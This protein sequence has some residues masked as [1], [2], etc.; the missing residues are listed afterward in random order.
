MI[1]RVHDPPNTSSRLSRPRKS[2]KYRDS[3][4]STSSASD[5]ESAEDLK[6]DPARVSCRRRRHE[7]LQA[8]LS[9]VDS[10]EDPFEEIVIRAETYFPN[11]TNIVRD[12]ASSYIV[13]Q[14]PYDTQPPTGPSLPPSIPRPYIQPRRPLLRSASASRANPFNTSTIAEAKRRAEEELDRRIMMYSRSH[15]NSFSFYSQPNYPGGGG[16]PYQQSGPSCGG[17]YCSQPQ[18]SQS[19]CNNFQSQLQQNQP[20]QQL[21]DMDER[22]TYDYRD[23]Q[24]ARQIFEQ[25]STMGQQQAA[26]PPMPRNHLHRIDLRQQNSVAS[27]NESLGGCSSGGCGPGAICPLSNAPQPAP[28][29]Q[30]MFNSQPT[31]MEPQNQESVN[32]GAIMKRE[33]RNPFAGG[34]GC[35]PGA[36]CGA[37]PDTPIHRG[38]G[39]PREGIKKFLVSEEVGPGGIKSVFSFPGGMEPS[40][41]TLLRAAISANAPKDAFVPEDN[42]DLEEQL[43]L[44]LEKTCM[45]PRSVHMVHEQNSHQQSQTS[46]PALSPPPSQHQNQPMYT[47]GRAMG[48]S[49]N[50]GNIMHMTVQHHQ[51]P[52]LPKSGPRQPPPPPQQDGQGSVRSENPLDTLLMNGISNNFVG[53][54]TPTQGQHSVPYFMCNHHQNSMQFPGGPRQGFG[55][56]YQT[57]TTYNSSRFDAMQAGDNSNNAGGVE[58]IQHQQS[59][60]AD[61]RFMMG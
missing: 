12:P 16:S 26:P 11:L 24:A 48:T 41:L 7:S 58:R 32:P 22:T 52:S 9:Y 56:N 51:R 60:N 39:N 35:G 3:V 2:S 31:Q 19:Q 33:P 1:F 61:N 55:G 53:P 40:D 45:D 18:C 27:T 47:V 29:F 42:E 15:R 13:E 20:Q 10:G 5:N 49:M 30:H 8:R 46:G 28:R 43:N 50:N 57:F 36:G 37:L 59:T 23:F 44:Q 21:Q 17:G 54:N 34:C 6:V 4:S 38:Q 14:A 25:K